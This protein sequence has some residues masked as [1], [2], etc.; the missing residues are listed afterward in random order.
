MKKI[1][2]FPSDSNLLV[3]W[4]KLGLVYDASKH[5]QDW[6]QHSALT[7]TPFLRS[8]GEIRVF[9]AFRDG[10]GVGRIGYVDLDPTD[11]TKIIA[12]SKKPVLD[13][14][15]EGCFDD[16]GVILGD[17]VRHDEKVYLFYVGFQHV[18]R[19]K[20]LAFTGLA[21]SEDDGESFQRVV[22]SPI[23]DRHPGE[24]YFAA[25]H[26]ALYEDGHWK[27][28]YGA[29]DAWVVI[30]GKSFPSYGVHFVKAPDLIRLPDQRQVCVA[31]SAIEY[32]IGRPRVY[33]TLQGY[34][35]HFTAGTLTGD[36]FPGIAFSSDGVDWKR[37]FG[38]FPVTLSDSGW[39]SHHLSYPS[40]LP[41]EDKAL[42]FYNGNDMGRDG[43]GVAECRDKNFIDLFYRATKSK[44]KKGSK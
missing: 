13:I 29:G 38:K 25:V 23:L 28:W 24:N 9:A 3:E 15:R 22:D 37:E 19:V 18:S 33:R 36:Y 7:P 10:E 8:S 34:L 27:L 21:I 1:E 5:I 35:M 39:D 2:K 31:P 6:A 41:M 20:F 40:I 44:F 30:N 42:M 16:N 26:T 11:P 4:K 12:I 32:R 14:G 43:F 17:V